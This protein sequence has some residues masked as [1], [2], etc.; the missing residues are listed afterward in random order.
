MGKPRP[1]RCRSSLEWGQP[2]RS[3]TT[4]RP[5][6]LHLL[7]A[8]ASSSSNGGVAPVSGNGPSCCRS[9]WVS[10][11]CG[12]ACVL[13]HK[14]PSPAVSFISSPGAGPRLR[15]PTVCFL[16]LSPPTNLAAGVQPP[17]LASAPRPG[18][19]GSK[20]AGSSAH[21]VLGAL[22]GFGS[23]PHCPPVPTPIPPH[24]ST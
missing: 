12:W 7:R 11:R 22:G 23:P 10:R 14:P 16:C 3:H 24:G 15:L 13:R 21:C 19:T 18:R 1:W 20:E 9:A 17:P 5:C 6:S 8:S 4:E 2:G